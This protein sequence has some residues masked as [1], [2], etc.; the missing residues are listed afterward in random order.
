MN[1]HRSSLVV[2]S[3][4]GGL[5]WS[6][7]PIAD[8]MKQTRGTGFIFFIDTGRA[9]TTRDN[10]IWIAEFTGGKIGTWRTSDGGRTWTQVESNEHPHGQMQI[11]QSNNGGVF[12]PAFHS[13]LGAGVFRSAD[14]GRTW[15]RVGIAMD[16]AA[17]FGT[18]KRV[19]AMHAWACGGSILDPA[20]QFAPQPGISGWVRMSTPP[21]MAIEPAQAAT[22]FDGTHYIVLTANWRGGLWRF[23][24]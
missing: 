11:Y 15:T 12:M 3:L 4:D 10:W 24:E 6:E 17:V 19:Y 21:E 23:V 8:G 5:N 2:E 1:G 16:Q 9:D 14:Y 7:V 13:D 20:L 22:V 18:P